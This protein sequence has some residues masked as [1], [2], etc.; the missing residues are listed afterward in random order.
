[1]YGSQGAVHLDQHQG[2]ARVLLPAQLLNLR[3]QLH[4]HP[5]VVIQHGAV[6]PGVEL[7]DS[8]VECA[9]RG[10]ASAENDCQA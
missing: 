10:Q 3:D 5:L 1:L 6:K 4:R 7:A 2:S 9:S 8:L